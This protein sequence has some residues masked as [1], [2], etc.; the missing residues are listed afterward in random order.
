M[1]EKRIKKQLKINGDNYQELTKDNMGN[2]QASGSMESNNISE[3][4]FAAKVLKRR[5]GFNGK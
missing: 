4:I 1:D 5:G 3:H 2:I